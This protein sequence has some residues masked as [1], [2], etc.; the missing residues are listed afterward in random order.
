[1]GKMLVKQ[2]KLSDLR[3]ITSRNAMYSR[4]AIVNTVFNTRIKQ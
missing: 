2:H 1:M 3:L 4:A